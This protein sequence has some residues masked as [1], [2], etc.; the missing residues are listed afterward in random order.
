ML[1]NASYNMLICGT[2]GSGKSYLINSI[3][4]GLVNNSDARLVL[5]DPKMV[6]LEGYRLASNCLWYADDEDQIFTVLSN[7]YDLM[8]YRYRKMKTAGTKSS[9][10]AHVFV[11]V[12]EMAALMQSSQKKE[13]IRMFSK[14]TLL[15]RAARVHLILCTQ[16]ATRDTIPNALRDNMANIVCLRQQDAG[17]QRY[18]LDCKLPEL[19]ERGWAYVKMPSLNRPQKVE[20]DAVWDLITGKEA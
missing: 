17:K 6:E 18:L 4:R 20:T 2:T 1:Q 14:M 13:Y 19:P 15:G 12:D 11:F 16:V 7:V 9:D 10:E 8:M 3:I 5:I